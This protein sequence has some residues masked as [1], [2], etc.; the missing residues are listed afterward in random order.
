[1]K[2]KI[3]MTMIVT[4]FVTLSSYQAKS[5][6]KQPS[7]LSKYEVA[8]DFTSLSLDSGTSLPGLGGRFT[9]NLNKHVALE[10]AGYFFPGKCDGCVG[11]I[12]GNV[13]EGLFGV[14]IGKRFK[15]WGIFGKA[16][17]GFASFSRGAFDIVPLASFS[18]PGQVSCFGTVPNL[19]PC[20]RIAETR[21]THA[22]LDLGGV[23]EF[24]PS[25]R[26]VVRFDGGDT[27]IHYTRRTFTTLVADPANP[28]SGIPVLGTF[29]GPAHTRHSFQFMGGVGFR[30]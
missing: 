18:G 3:L 30:F 4:A 10:T 17:P 9:F 29:I 24:Y 16:R 26:I 2:S 1:M 7:D 21:R 19:V 22:V 8:A 12:T 11:E 27:M 25:K 14:K 6:T 28:T 20:F 13:T 23:L 5:Q 15:K